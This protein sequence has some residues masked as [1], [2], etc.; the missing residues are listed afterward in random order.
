MTSLRKAGGKDIYCPQN[1]EFNHKIEN[2]LIM[3]YCTY[4]FIYLYFIDVTL[5]Y[6]II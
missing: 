1:M 2:L 5:I 6:D 3:L 4:L